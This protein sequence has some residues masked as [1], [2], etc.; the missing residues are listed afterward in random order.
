MKYIDFIGQALLLVATLILTFMFFGTGILLGQFLL[1]VW[2]MLSSVVSVL[3]NAPLRKK[4]AIHLVCSFSYLSLLAII[5]TN[6]WW[7]NTPTAFVL[8][9]VPAWILAIYY[10][11][12]TWTW[13]FAEKSRS[14]FLPNIS[15]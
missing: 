9:M 4:K 15:F 6:N 13:A 14:K 12:V 10:F 3:G 5:Y 8:M 1:G 7:S 2:Q 11:T